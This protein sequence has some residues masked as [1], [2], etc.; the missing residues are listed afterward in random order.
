VG[1]FIPA[2]VPLVKIAQGD[3]LSDGAADDF[4]RAFDIGPSRTLQQ[5]VEFGVLQIVDIALRAISPAI[6]DP[7][8]AINGI[9]Q[10]S[11]ILIRFAQRQEPASVIYDLP[12]EPQLIVPWINFEGLL[13]SAFEQ[14]RHY[15]TTDAAVCLRLL[16]ALNDI[17]VSTNEPAF[18]MLALERGKRVLNGCA[19]D[20][21]E[22]QIHV[23]QARLD[24]LEKLLTEGGPA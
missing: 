7:S 4:R 21:L 8:T 12:G 24:S 1:H 15:G 2:G 20:R 23:M 11:R 17:A 19:K 3:R 18:R 16:R 22:E 9:D 6:N 14:I 10:L 13:D 5:D